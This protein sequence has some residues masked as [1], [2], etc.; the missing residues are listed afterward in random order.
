[1]AD[2][3]GQLDAEQTVEEAVRS[4]GYDVKT[5]LDN[6]QMF[7]WFRSR[8]FTPDILVRHDDQAVMIEVKTRPV[9]LR[10]VYSIDLAR[11]GKKMGAVI[12]VSDDYFPRIRESSKSY[13]ND[14]GV[15]LCR[16]SEVGDVLKS[17]LG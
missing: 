12:C 10:D 8:Q 9:M 17:M 3:S 1:M 5:G 14:V 2:I 15:R 7:G 16:L 4:L 6:D 13:A 11:K